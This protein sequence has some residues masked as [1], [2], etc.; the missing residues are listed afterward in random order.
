MPTFLGL[1]G[2][3]GPEA[4]TGLDFWPTVRGEAVRDHV[5][6]GFGWFGAVR[7][8]EWN[9]V[10]PCRVLPAGRAGDPEPRLYHVT[11]DPGEQVN[12]AEK[13]PEVVEEMKGLARR[14]WP[15]L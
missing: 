2:V 1:L 10:F 15:H 6:T 9:Y 3:D 8:S 4:M 12:V 13:H 5:V 7:T 14:V 11:E